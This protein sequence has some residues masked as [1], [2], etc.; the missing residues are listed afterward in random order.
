MLFWSKA[1]SMSTCSY[2]W[3]D[4][5]A[6][7]HRHDI[8]TSNLFDVIFRPPHLIAHGCL[9]VMILPNELI[10]L[11]DH[12]TCRLPSYRRQSKSLAQQTQMGGRSAS[13]KGGNPEY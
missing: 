10:Y 2:E 13:E 5:F 8:A 1:K 9:V 6:V 3:F 11:L 4:L 7:S 12:Q